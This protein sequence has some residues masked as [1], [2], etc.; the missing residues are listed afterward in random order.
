MLFSTPDEIKNFLPQNAA[1]EMQQISSFITDTEDT[2][3]VDAI[4][5]AQYDLLHAAY[6]NANISGALE[7]LLKKVRRPL[8]NYAYYKYIPFAQLTFS[9]SGIH[10]EVNEQKRSAFPEMIEKLEDAC[11]E[12]ANTG[13][14]NLLKWME[15]NKADYAAWTGSTAYTV[16]KECFINTA[17]EFSDHFNIGNSRRTFLALKGTMKKVEEFSIKP[18]LCSTLFDAIKVEIK[19]GTVSP[20]NTALLN[21]IKP[22]VA[23]LT[24]ARAL[25]M[26]NIEFTSDGC[27]L[28]AT[29][30]RP[31]LKPRPAAPADKIGAMQLAAQTDAQVYLKQ[32]N[33]YLYANADTYPTWKSSSCYIDPASDAAAPF[34]QSNNGIVGF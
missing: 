12:G 14:E 8:A 6:S 3:I 25:T 11:I 29:R 4:G 21:F 22:A 18:I 9:A 28:A 1:F 30:D 23:L 27:Q 19:S 32:L 13:I 7:K 2:L 33:D 24:G 20:S 15:A 16:F 17:T 26:P 31:P 5:Q 34:D 10:I